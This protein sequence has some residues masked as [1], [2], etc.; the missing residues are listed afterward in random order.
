MDVRQYY[1]KLH[2]LEAGMP[3]AYAVVVSYETPDGGKAG[4]L[5]EVTRRNACELLLE[6][7]ARVASPAEAEEFRQN[8]AAK[9]KEF[10]LNRAA[11]K[12][13]VHVV[14]TEMGKPVPARTGN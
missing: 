1:K 10:E 6:G 7:R 14:A 11:S 13:Q 5:T 3:E 8:E 4:V 2:E 9:R 12:V